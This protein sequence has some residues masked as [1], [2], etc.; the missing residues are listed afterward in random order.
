MSSNALPNFN[1]LRALLLLL[2]A[3]MFF[4]LLDASGKYLAADMGIPL[5]ALVRHG[6]QVVLMLLLF[7]PRLRL[8]R[9]RSA[10]PT[11][12]LLRGLVLSAFTLFF[13]TA[14]KY[15]PQAEATAITF[16]APLI[17]MLLAGPLLGEKVS[18]VRWI[19]AALGFVGMLVVVRPG[20]ALAMAG[21]LFALLTVGCNVAFQLLTRKL[22]AADDSTTTLFVS[23]LIAT[24]MSALMLPL[25][26]TWGGWPVRLDQTQLVLMASLGVLGIIGQWCFIRAYVWSSASFIAPLVYLQLSWSTLSGWWF[27]GQVPDALSACGMLL[28]G[29]S[30]VA[31]MWVE[32][33]ARWRT[34]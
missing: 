8:W 17:V 20:T 16:V 26:D 34:K 24:L 31:V 22:A 32:T 6:G 13:F 30:G 10:H 11:L 7:G 14:L 21:V 3:Q 5:I 9:L 15:L 1:P 4:A 2:C 18:R 28:I 23:A 12:Q 33:H 25:Q 27:F 19:G 29:G